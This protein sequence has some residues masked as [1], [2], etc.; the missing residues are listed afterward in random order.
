MDL[1][2]L[3]KNLTTGCYHIVENHHERH[4]YS[5]LSDLLWD[6]EIIVFIATHQDLSAIFKAAISSQKLRKFS[7]FGCVVLLVLAAWLNWWIALGIL[8]AYGLTWYFWKEAKKFSVM[9]S[10]LFLALE[11]VGND[12]AGL[13]GR[14][15]ILQTA[16]DR[17]DKYLPDKR[18]KFMDFYLPRRAEADPKFLEELGMSFTPQE[19]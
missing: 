11:M 19:A 17:L 15:R 9:V 10:A 14:L 4:G 13:G 3:P 2:F 7:I 5:E 6:A 12:F 8:P 16:R 18:T 1:S